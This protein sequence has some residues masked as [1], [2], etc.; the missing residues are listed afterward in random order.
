MH[1]FAGLD[2]RP[3]VTVV[4]GSFN[5]RILLERAIESVRANL[6]EGVRGEI[7][8]IDGGSNDGSIEWLV[9]QKDIITIIQHNRYEHEGAQRRRMS[10]GRFMNITFRAAGA[11][12]IVMISD[13]CYLLPGALKG[14]LRRVAEAE[15]AGLRVGGCAFYFRDWPH[16]E[17]YFV[18]RTVGGN[19][20]INHGLYKREALENCGYANEDDF[21]FYK[22]D[23]DLSLAIWAAGFSIIDAPAAICE[24]FMSPEERVRVTNTATLDFDREQLQRRWAALTGPDAVAKMGKHYLEAPASDAIAQRVFGDQLTPVARK[25]AQASAA[26]SST[27]GA[28]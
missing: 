16:D 9:A 12:N 8:V 4:L 27:Y 2:P 21:V 19:L 28:A 5:R 1:A 22:A 24:H 23:S 13:D 11:E 3:E 20:M 17:R 26:D 7:V 6:A 18:Q 14:A 15:D 25:L 10:W